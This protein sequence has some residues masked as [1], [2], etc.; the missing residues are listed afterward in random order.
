M[1]RINLR[2]TCLVLLLAAGSCATQTGGSP[3]ASAAAAP[4]TAAP[5]AAT[6]PTAANTDEKLRAILA[7]SHRSDANRQR[8]RY[9]HPVETLG[10]F[11]LREDM[12]V[13]ELWPGNGWYTEVL[14][15]FLKDKGKLL[16]TNT[17]NGKK[18]G[19]FLAAK[20]DIYG[21]VEVRTIAPPTDINLGPDGSVDL[22]VT[23]RN[24]HNWMPNNFEDKV[25]A[26]AYRVLKPGGVFGVVEHRGKPGSDPAELKDTG[27]VPED[28][29]IRK[30]E[31]AGLKLAGKSEI[32]ANPKDTKDYAKG[33]W[34]LPPTLRLGD[35]DKD[36]YLAIG[37]SDRMTLRFVKP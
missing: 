16:V 12:T 26:A 10:F 25:F 19:E 17:A 20:P 1:K 34:T 8:D 35:Q 2:L 28:F 18:Y 30:V 7:M 11:G 22:V 31:Q 5:P 37:E 3:Q 4:G 24:I 29:V 6:P 27:Y 9:R 33:V 13:L 32:N 21:K 15:P 23:F 14:A 36:K